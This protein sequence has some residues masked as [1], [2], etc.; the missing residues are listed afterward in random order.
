MIT[1]TKTR[2]RFLSWII[3]LLVTLPL[4]ALAQKTVSGVVFEEDG[5]TPMTGATVMQKG[6]PRNAVSTDIDGKFTLKVTGKKPV[7]VV[8]FIGYNPAEVSA[9]PGTPLKITMKPN[10]VQLDDVVVTALGITR[11]QKSLGYAVSKVSNEELTN[12]VSGNWLNAMNGKV[13]GLTM[14]AAGT[15]PMSSVR[16]VLRGDQSLNYGANEALFVI[17]G[18]PMSSGTT[19][20]GSGSGMTNADASVDFGNDAADINPEDVESVT[21]LK[22]PAATALYGSRAANGAIVITTKSGKT[23]KGVGVTVNS[24]VTW[25]KASYWPDFQKEYGPGNTL[26]QRPYSP[27][28]ISADKSPTGNRIYKNCGNLAAGF[29][30]RFDPNKIRFNY[31]SYDFDNDTYSGTPFVYADDWYTGIWRTGVTYNNTVTI[32][33]GNGKGTQG[34]VSITDTRNDWVLPNTGYKKDAISVAF[35]TKLNK[36]IS[37]DS[38]VQYYNKRSDNVPLSGYNQNNINYMLLWLNNFDPYEAYVQEY[39]SGRLSDPKITPDQYVK[40]AEEN[41]NISNPLYY[42]YEAT[43]SMQKNRVIGNVGINIKFPVKGLTLKLRGAMDMNDEFRAMRKAAKTY[44]YPTGGY[45]EQSIRKR[46]TNMDFLLRYENNRWFSKRLSFNISGG[47]NSM[48]LHGYNQSIQLKD[49]DIPGIYNVNNAPS[50]SI[51]IPMQI[52]SRKVV[53]SLYAFASL[54]WENTYFLDVTARNDWSS[55]LARGNWSFF[56][57]SVAASV[58]LDQ[59]FKIQEHAPWVDMLKVRASWANVGNDTNPYSLLEAYNSTNFNGSFVLPGTMTNP[60][61]KPENVESWEAG[62]EARFFHNRIGIDAA[63][64]NSSTTNQIVSATVDPIAGASGMRINAGEIRNKG[65][66]LALHLEPIQTRDFTWTLD[67]NWSRN[68]NKLVSLQDGWDPNTPLEVNNGA[69]VKGT[70]ACYSYVGRPMSQ[71]YGRGYKRAPEGAFYTDAA[72]NKVDCSGMLL[73]TANDGYPQLT[74]NADIYLGN[75]NPDWNGGF[76]TRFRYKNV[77]L[78]ATFTASYGGHAY[79]MTHAITAYKG[80]LKNSLPGRQGGLVVE[81]VNEIT[82]PDGSISYQKNNTVTSAI[83]DYYAQYKFVRTNAE[84]NTFSTAFFKMKELRLDVSLPKKLCRQSKVLRSASLGAFATNIFCITDWPQ[85]DP[86]SSGV[87]SGTDIYRGIESASMPMT[88]TY[89][90]NIKLAF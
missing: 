84:E 78:S 51:P 44:K 2:A 4:S 28:N 76:S 80:K 67:F 68:W 39:F 65:I 55:T 14:D 35:R 64:Y 15:G 17:D 34:R 81:G 12:T 38:R 74:D 63:V 11:E 90:V 32:E 59:A 30:E 7:V 22:G 82:N 72:G 10:S 89:G 29:G 60:L 50:T 43:N 61:I 6:H 47:G 73:I 20:S 40:P 3:A 75:A 23:E 79:S 71:L 87:L 58:L 48:E 8:T 56:Y 77:S 19:E 62:I 45:K 66:E 13:A 33:G 70:I 37:V 31:L 21:V 85:F 42:L 88:R 9:T 54:G 24:S 36:W 26:G 27:W 1:F 52:R 49:L 46:E 53:N 16:V 57:P 18:V 69:S 86:E 25:E 5:T 41:D 83:N